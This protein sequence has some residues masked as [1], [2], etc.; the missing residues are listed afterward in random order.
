MCCLADVFF[1]WGGLKFE[2]MGYPFH[3]GHENQCP[4]LLYNFS[5]ENYII[6]IYPYSYIV[7]NINYT[8]NLIIPHFDSIQGLWFGFSSYKMCFLGGRA[9]RKVETYHKK[10]LTKSLENPLPNP[11]VLV[12][13][14]HTSLLET[15]FVNLSCQ[16]DTFVKTYRIHICMN[17]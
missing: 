9:S 10:P 17:S 8:Y 12:H 5:C 14:C 13:Q 16:K 7:Y 11:L 15:P 6:Y 4:T 3:F 1:V 2:T